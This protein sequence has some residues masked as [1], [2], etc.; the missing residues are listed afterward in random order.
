M[1]RRMDIDAEYAFIFQHGADLRKGLRFM[2][3][4]ND[5]HIDAQ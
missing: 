5:P 4:D 3:I 1:L 2:R